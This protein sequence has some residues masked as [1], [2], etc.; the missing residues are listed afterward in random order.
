VFASSG[1]PI[2]TGIVADLSRP[3]SNV[4]GVLLIA[5]DLSAKWLAMLHTPWGTLA[6]QA[7]LSMCPSRW[8]V[9]IR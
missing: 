6:P 4:T 1:N 8:K 7:S 9:P 3:G 5:S 2:S